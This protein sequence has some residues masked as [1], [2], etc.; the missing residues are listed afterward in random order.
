MHDIAWCVAA[1]AGDAAR[2]DG[3]GEARHG[4]RRP[5]AG[6]VRP[7]VGRVLLPGALSARPEPI[8]ARQPRQQKGSNRVTGETTRGKT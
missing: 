8:H 3:G 4:S 7:G 6:H 2:G 1:G 5:L